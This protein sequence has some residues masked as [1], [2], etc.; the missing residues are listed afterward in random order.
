MIE[1]GT[2]L[3]SIENVKAAPIPLLDYYRDLNLSVCSK[4]STRSYI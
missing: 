4:G 1:A 2:K 3:N